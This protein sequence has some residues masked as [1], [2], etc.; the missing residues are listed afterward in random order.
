MRVRPR[1]ACADVWLLRQKRSSSSCCSCLHGGLLGSPNRLRANVL[2]RLRAALLNALISR[3]KLLASIHTLSTGLVPVL[4]AHLT[5]R[6]TCLPGG[7]MSVDR[8]IEFRVVIHL[9]LTVE[10]EAPLAVEDL[11]PERIQTCGE[12]ISLLLEQGKAAEVLLVVGLGR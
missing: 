3:G 1:R 11:S 5:R 4:Y 10:F 9:Q 6:S 7:L 12:V 2:Y 8:R